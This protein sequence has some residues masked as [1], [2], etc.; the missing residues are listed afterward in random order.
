MF[1]RSTDVA[2]DF[3]LQKISEIVLDVCD[4]IDPLLF[5]GTRVMHQAHLR[6]FPLFRHT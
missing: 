4:E 5:C 2:Q 3:A 1:D 6:F